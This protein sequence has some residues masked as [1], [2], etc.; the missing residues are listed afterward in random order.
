MLSPTLLMGK[1]DLDKEEL[2]RLIEMAW[3]DRTPFDAI[4]KQYGLKENDVMKLMQKNLKKSSY[5]LWRKRV[6]E[7]GLKH[8][9]K[10]GFITSNAYVTNQYK[11]KSQLDI[12]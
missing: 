5:V 2:S 3:E 9:K 11:Q 10:R 6:K 8:Q 12:L 4:F 1:F 7:I